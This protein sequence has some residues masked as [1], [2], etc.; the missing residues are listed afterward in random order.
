[1]TD[2]LGQSIG[3]G[4]VGKHS[5][6]QLWNPVGSGKN[7]ELTSVRVTFTTWGATPAGSRAGDFVKT[8]APLASKLGYAV[9]A[10]FGDSTSPVAEMRSEA[11]LPADITGVA[12]FYECWIGASETDRLYQFDKPIIIRP[13]TGFAVRGAQTAMY[14]VSAWQWSEDA[15]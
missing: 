3:D 1:L 4:V 11:K 9:A 15:V 8:T 14:I 7:L 5:H 12:P 2:Y 13:G 10:D 6:A